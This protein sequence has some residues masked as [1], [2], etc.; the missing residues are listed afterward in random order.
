MDRDA[1]LGSLLRVLRDARKIVLT[2]HVCPDGDGLGSEVALEALAKRF[3]A[4]VRVINRDPAPPQLDF[5]E[6]DGVTPARR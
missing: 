5:L 2:T 6:S 1:A 3:G 4:T